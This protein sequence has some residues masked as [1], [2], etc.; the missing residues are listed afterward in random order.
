MR[1]T[2][3]ESE[4]SSYMQVGNEERWYT[5]LGTS[6]ERRLLCWVQA[7]PCVPAIGGSAHVSVLTRPAS[8]WWL[9]LHLRPL[10]ASPSLLSYRPCAPG[11][12]QDL[13]FRHYTL[14][15]KIA[16][17]TYNDEQ[18]VRVTVTRAEPPNFVQE[19]KVRPGWGGRACRCQRE[20]C[21]AGGWRVPGAQ[22]ETARAW[23]QV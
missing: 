21:W 20:R 10:P 5:V 8:S 17:D 18:K 9:C 11:L 4:F 16:S 22:D 14:K 7:A 23:P 12:P 15:L 13:T 3:G 1:E 19:S 6:A 2:L